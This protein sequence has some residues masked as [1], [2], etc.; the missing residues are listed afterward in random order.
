MTAPLAVFDLGKTNS[1][2]FVF[3][4]AGEILTEARTAPQWRHQDGM[5]VL[6]DGRLLAW[7]NASLA[8]AVDRHGVEGVMFSAHGCTFAL[9][10]GK[11][12]AHPILDYEQE[13]PDGIAQ[14]IAALLPDF[15]E[16]YSPRLPLGLNLARHLLW[17]E[18]AA[19]GALAGT[20]HIL[21]YPQFWSWRF[22]GVAVSE[23]SYLGCHSHLW[24]PLRRDFSS[25]VDVRGWREKMPAFARAG[26]ELGQ[27][28]I[29]LPSGGRRAVAV[30]N[31]VH[32]SSS[33]FYRYLAAGHR[34]FTLV[35]TGTWVII[36][37][38]D[39]PLN[40]LDEKRD[41][42]TNVTVDGA[43]TPTI[44]FMGGREFDV[45]RNGA[46]P[47]ITGE[48]LKTVIT[49]KVF[50]LPSFAVGG[51]LPETAGEIVGQ[52][53]T[54]AER[55]ALALL[56]VVLMTDYCLDLIGSANTII[57]DGGLV[58]TGFYAEALARL[59]P[60][61][62]VLSSD[63]PE[64]SAT[65]AAALAYE[66]KGVAVRPVACAE[67]APLVLPDLTEYR[68]AWRELVERRREREPSAA[69]RHP[70]GAGAP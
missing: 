41:M 58:R 55:A 2:L 37:N 47:E 42:L 5:R 57:V 10:D 64:G 62:R 29:V 3:S 20:R 11:G 44:R 15:A 21:G 28:E 12:L 19:P 54:E 30:H 51:P 50:A 67:V 6:D 9:V 38:T 40:A 46:P 66:A 8:D 52:V 49:R 32:D 63:Q 48:A 60:G 45:I 4:P 27:A 34:S 17:V 56:Y 53:G 33:A 26:A 65:G 14:E 23:I 61:Q 69:S 1:K 39:C 59:R 35:S 31:G 22:C 43:P 70:A 24:A 18:R 25:L 16:T 13:V 68:T 7:M 36:F